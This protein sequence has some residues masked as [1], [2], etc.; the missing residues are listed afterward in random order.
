VPGAADWHLAPLRMA[1]EGLSVGELCRAL[2]DPARGGMRPDQFVAH[3]R[4][5]L[6]RWAWAP[7]VDSHGRSRSRP[8]MAYEQF[9]ALTQEWVTKGAACPSND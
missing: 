9:M 1:W 4:T 7:G 3:V 6:V 5:G 8:P 2:L